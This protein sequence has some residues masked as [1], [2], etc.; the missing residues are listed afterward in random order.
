MRAGVLC[1]RAWRGARGARAAGAHARAC[2][3]GRVSSSVTPPSQRAHVSH[4]QQRCVEEEQDAEDEE[5]H[6]EGG[7]PDAN[8]CGGVWWAILR[9]N[10]HKKESATHGNVRRERG[11][12][13]V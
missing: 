4:G 5:H 6:A 12:K 7:Q 10:T 1:V 13:S 2:A 9:K 3:S 8:L 11:V